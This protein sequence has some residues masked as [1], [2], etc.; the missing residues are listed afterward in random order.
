MADD[1]AILIV[2]DSMEKAERY[3]TLMEDHDISVESSDE[4][5]GKKG[6]VAVLVPED[7]LEEAKYI[8]RQADSFADDAENEFDSF[9][10]DG[11][12]DE[13]DDYS[14]FS[15]LD[16]DEDDYGYDDEDEDD[17]YGGDDEEDDGYGGY[18][19]YGNEEDDDYY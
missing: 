9:D 5:G 10:D 12:E 17:I 18:G 4:E 8:L 13:E 6:S 14:D 2:V 16:D 11:M 15:P 19:G 3:M 7:M 1:M